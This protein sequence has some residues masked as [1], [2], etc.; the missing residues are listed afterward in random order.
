M[1][2]L[3]PAKA[4]TQEKAGHPAISGP[5]Q[6][7][8][9]SFL[10]PG[11]RRDERVWGSSMRY[12]PLTPEDRAEMLS[13]VGAPSIEALFADVPASA[14]LAGPVDLPPHQGELEVERALG[15]LAAR[16]RPAGTEIGRASCR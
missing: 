16:N 14:R 10:G 9:E 11:L 7:F 4:G 5:L 3:I 1:S 2:P 8:I 15:R 6:R 12:L 13:V